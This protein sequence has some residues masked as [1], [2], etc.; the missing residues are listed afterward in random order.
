VLPHDAPDDPRWNELPTIDLDG[1]VAAS[2]TTPWSSPR[3]KVGLLRA[4]MTHPGDVIDKDAL[5]T[6]AW[7]GG[8]PPSNSLNVRLAAP[9]EEASRPSASRS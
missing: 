9:P 7:P 4:F 1:R 3:S 5:M 2:V 8:A 6:S